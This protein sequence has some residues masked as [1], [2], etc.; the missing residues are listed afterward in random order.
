MAYNSK[1]RREE[2]K[3][4]QIVSNFLEKYFY[5][6]TNDYERVEDK[7]RQLKGIDVIFNFKNKQYVCDEKAA[8]RYIN[9]N[10]QTFAFELSFLGKNDKLI[11]GWLISERK[12]NNSFLCI[13]IDKADYDFIEDIDDIKEVEIALIDKQQLL[14]YL[15]QLG[16]NINKL[17]TKAEKLRNNEK[18]NC[19][20]INKHGCKFSCSRY[21]PEQPVNVIVA[22]EK[23]KEI[24][25]YNQKFIVYE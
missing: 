1:T 10:L 11:E 14:N 18:E 24:S 2:E 22:R 21:L 25:D 23:L 7:E 9:K 3:M 6:N 5:S 17:H 19:G 15:K 12:V 13:W 16:W 8:I 4:T 20:N